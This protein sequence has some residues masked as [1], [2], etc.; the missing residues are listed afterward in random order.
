MLN[1][2]AETIGES[3]SRK[4]KPR[5]YIMKQDLSMRQAT[6]LYKNVQAEVADLNLTKFQTIFSNQHCERN[7]H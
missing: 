5:Q 1:E 7:I 3:T 4:D 6:V 2:Q